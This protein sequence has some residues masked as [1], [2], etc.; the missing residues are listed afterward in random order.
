MVQ[1][2]DVVVRRAEPEDAPALHA[3][4]SAPSVY[5]GL[6]QLPFPSVRVWRQR[7]EE[8]PEGFRVLVA[9]HGDAHGEVVGHL[10]LG[11]STQARMGHVATL[12]MAVREEWQGRGV[13]TVLMDAAVDLADNWLQVTRIELEVY[14]D[15][16]P[17]RALYRKFDFVAEGTKRSAVFRDGVYVD[18][19]LMARLHPRLAAER[20]D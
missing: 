8:P 6:M 12:G 17:A 13:G 3:S 4:M 15:N 2:P 19:Y 14:V 9:C 5:R 11:V 20:D 18:T 10:G 1:R 7:L 16:E